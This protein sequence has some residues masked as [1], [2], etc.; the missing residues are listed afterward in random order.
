MRHCNKLLSHAVFRPYSLFLESVGPLNNYSNQGFEALSRLMKRYL[1]IRTNKGGGQ[2]KSK[3]KLRPITFLFLR[4]LIWT[5]NVYMEF[6]GKVSYPN[7][8]TVN[9]EIFD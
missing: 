4:H 7:G 1:N 5:F 8:S 3:S 2:S 6:D 9:S